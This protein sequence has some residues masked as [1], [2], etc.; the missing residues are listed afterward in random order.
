[1]RDFPDTY[2]Y[3]K[4]MAEHLLAAVNIKASKPV[5]IV[6]IRPSIVAA[7]AIEPM[8]G[9]TDT[10]GLLSGLT[11]ALGLGVLKDM[12]GNPEAC[13][14]IIPVD[15]VAHQILASA[16]F[17][18]MHPESLNNERVLVVH[19]STS[20]NNPVTYEKFFKALI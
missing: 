16:A 12:P 15:I 19:S 4:R 1:M 9:W 17:A 20:A 2:S 6:M 8:E 13:A 14:D 3:S 7:A 11:L 10:D 18:T 5:N